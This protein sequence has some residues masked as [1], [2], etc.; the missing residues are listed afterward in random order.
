MTWATTKVSVA[1]QKGLGSSIEQFWPPSDPATVGARD[2]LAITVDRKRSDGAVVSTVSQQLRIDGRMCLLVTVEIANADPERPLPTDETFGT[3]KVVFTGCHALP[4]FGLSHG[5]GLETYV[6]QETYIWELPKWVHEGQGLGTSIPTHTARAMRFLVAQPEPTESQV[7]C[8]RW[9]TETCLTGYWRLAAFPTGE[10]DAFELPVNEPEPENLEVLLPEAAFQWSQANPRSLWGFRFRPGDGGDDAEF[11]A[12]PWPQLR[13]TPD[14]CYNIDR[15]LLGYA[16]HQPQWIYDR[17]YVETPSPEA[18]KFTGNLSDHSRNRK[19]TPERH[20]WAA[21]ERYKKGWLC[22]ADSI[23]HTA[24]PALHLAHYTGDPY[25]CEKAIDYGYWLLNTIHTSRYTIQQGGYDCHLM[26]IPRFYRM[27]ICL[28]QCSIVAREWGKVFPRALNDAEVFEQALVRYVHEVFDSPWRQAGY[29][30]YEIFQRPDGSGQVNG[31]LAVAVWQAGFPIQA[32]WW[33]AHNL[34]RD[35]DSTN[36]TTLGYRAAQLVTEWARMV[37]ASWSFDPN[38]NQWVMGKLLE[39]TPL[40]SP[41]WPYADRAFVHVSLDG[42]VYWPYAGLK[43]VQLWNPELITNEQERE[44]LDTVV[45]WLENRWPDL[46]TGRW[47]NI[48]GPE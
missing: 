11:G 30:D 23:E 22:G 37:L 8:L 5:G 4:V 15:R 12:D 31:K 14:A 3:W 25:W 40:T 19:G 47:G 7:D 21:L 9:L 1:F 27:V 6:P 38:A 13:A 45:L 43:L 29:P 2:G 18:W 20:D 34:G 24:L 41:T 44:V 32:F 39:A 26:P 35:N 17:R 46:R 36:V 48:G 28:I 10:K 33:I 16:N 42:L